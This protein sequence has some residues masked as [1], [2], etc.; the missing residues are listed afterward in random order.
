MK[1]IKTILSVMLAAVMLLSLAA[2]HPANETAVTVGEMEVP[3]GIYLCAMIQ[4][5]G[6]ARNTVDAALAAESEDSTGVDAEEINYYKEKIDG[7]DFTKWV[8]DRTL[9]MV[10]EY[11]VYTTLFNEAGLELDDAT[12]EELDYMADYYWNSYGY[13]EIY[14]PNGVSYES[15]KEFFTYSYRT[16]AYFLSI[17]GEGGTN[18]VSE[19]ELN[20]TIT[21]NF[22]VAK[23]LSVSYSTMDEDGNTVEM[24]E[25]EIKTVQSRIASYGPLLEGGESFEKLYLGEY[26][27]TE[28]TEEEEDEKEV[29]EAASTDYTTIFVSEEA[30][31]YC[32]S[33]YYSYE[34]FEEVKALEVGK[35]YTVDDTDAGYSAVMFKAQDVLKYED[36]QETLKETALY[37]LKEEEFT[38]D[39]Q[40][41]IDETEFSVNDYAIDRFKPKNIDYPLGAA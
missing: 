17:Y 40:A 20:K 29:D 8:K 14:E 13:S 41:I 24:S 4:A 16:R 5:D 18:A 36:Y 10:K 39:V 23:V 26:P 37:I 27:A 32:S 9:Q 33:Q 34:H 6:E 30:Q 2:C 15:Y 1:K 11:A 3:A 25:D 28:E 38:A 31:P 35:T 12:K 21:D 7:T 22:A 19:D